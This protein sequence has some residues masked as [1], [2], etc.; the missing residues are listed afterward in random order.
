LY[1]NGVNAKTLAR[2]KE[3][4]NLEMVEF[5]GFVS[6]PE[7]IWTTEHILV[8]PSRVEGLPLAVVEAMLCGRPCIVTDV[9]GN[10]EVVEDNVTGFVAAAP[11]PALL[12]EAMERAWNRRDD[13]RS[14]GQAAA[15][16]IRE[17]IPCDPVG[18]FIAEIKQL[19]T[20]S[21]L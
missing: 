10:T 2:L 8:L 5:A 17:L 3:L 21:V 9:A 20:Q 4:W 13:W 1:G 15:R 7:D 16:R 18:E 12:D 11:T 6:N 19:L 14:I